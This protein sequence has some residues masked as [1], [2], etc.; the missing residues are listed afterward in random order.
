MYVFK[1]LKHRHIPSRNISTGDGYAHHW[2]RKD[3]WIVHDLLAYWDM[4]IGL[5]QWIEKWQIPKK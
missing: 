2:R 4:Y 1:K 5:I 3:M